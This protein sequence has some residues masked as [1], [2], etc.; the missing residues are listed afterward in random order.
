MV[1]FKRPE[2]EDRELINHYLAKQKSR[3]CESTFAN[4]YLWSRFFGIEFAEINNTLVFKDQ[5]E[6]PSFVFPVGSTEDVKGTIDILMESCREQNIPYQMHNITPE[7]FARIEKWYPAEFEIEYN[8]NAADY[9]YEREKLA[10]LSGKKYHGKKNHTNKFQKLYP[11]WSYESIDSRN[12]EDCFQMA[13]KWRNANG[14][15]DDEEKNAEICVTLNALRLFNELELCG[16]LLRANRE[17]VAFSIG[18]PLCDDTFVVHIEKAFAD[19]PGAYPM[20][21]QQFVIHETEGYMYINREE[22]MG[23]EGLRTAKLSYRPIF[24]VEKGRVRKRG[25]S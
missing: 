12:L 23:E 20:I 6:Q 21:N 8:R 24:L 18:E 9:V 16:G 19:I 17:I 4:T 14:C 7:Q 25:D 13:L 22:D 11:D 5:Q 3:N 1:T 15:E 2:L 10:L